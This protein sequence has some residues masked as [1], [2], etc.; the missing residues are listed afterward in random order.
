MQIGQNSHIYARIYAIQRN[1]SVKEYIP[2]SAG[3][4]RD[5]DLGALG[6]R[7][8]EARGQLLR[9]GFAY[10]ENANG[11]GRDGLQELLYAHHSKPVNRL[12]GPA[13][14]YANILVQAGIVC[15]GTL[16]RRM[17]RLNSDYHVYRK[18]FESLLDRCNQQHVDVQN[19]YQ[20]NRN[21]PNCSQWNK[22]RPLQ[23]GLAP[24]V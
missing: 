21:G 10:P 15:T 13:S 7:P 22:D 5:Q 8:V 23:S 14:A 2:G 11:Q 16:S 3:I 4:S 19:E 18:G 17:S 12:R 24:S 1:G 9:G 20:A 6:R